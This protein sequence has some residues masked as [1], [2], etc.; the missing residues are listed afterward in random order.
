VT[1]PK[2]IDREAEAPADLLQLIDVAR[3]APQSGIDPLELL[4][5]LEEVFLS[6]HQVADVSS[7]LRYALHN[8][9]G[10]YAK[11]TVAAPPKGDSYG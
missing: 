2:A 6:R 4:D 10:K 3:A 11:Q 9:R 1:D 8:L 7:S 5:E